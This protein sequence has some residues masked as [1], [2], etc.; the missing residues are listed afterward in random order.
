MASHNG[1]E[2]KSTS[3][4]VRDRIKEFKRVRAA[5]L[6]PNPKNWRRH[7]KAQS[8]A[9]RGLLSEIGYAGARITR[10]PPHVDRRPPP[11]PNHARNDGASVGARSRCGG[12]R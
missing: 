3:I 7:P 9:L 11:R 8:E 4:L 2:A 5:D 12:G 6:V 10:W 1:A